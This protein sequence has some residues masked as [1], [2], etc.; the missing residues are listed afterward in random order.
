M[1]IEK[2]EI[3]AVLNKIKGAIPGKTAVPALQGVLLQNGWLTA[4][5]LN[6]GISAKLNVDTGETF[7]IPARAI[8]MIDAL[9]N[10]PVEITVDDFSIVHIKTGS[11][12]NQFASIP[13]FEFPN[14][15]E[16]DADSE[17]VTVDIDELQDAITSVLYAVS[18][19]EARPVFTGVLLEAADGYLNIVSCDGYRLAWNRLPFE[20][21]FNMI[22]PKESV[23]K[24][25]SLG[26][27]GNVEI[28]FDA[29]RAI[30]NTPEYTVFTRLL[31]GKFIDYSKQFPVHSIKVRAKRQLLMD[32]IHR[33]MICIDA[34]VKNPIR[35][36]IDGRDVTLSL[37]LPTSE[38]TESL[39][40]EDTLGKSLIIGFNAQ[41][42]HDALKSFPR[43]IVELGINTEI[44][45]V[46]IE[47]GDHRAMVLPVRLKA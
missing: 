3:S 13:V 39:N 26:I 28:S 36:E 9:P 43:D 45:P 22:L 40:F 2:A 12:K 10:G 16:V 34:K 11:I 32:C 30:F 46:T 47:D 24:L 31:D 15:P 21:V 29:K 33:A 4:Y 44:S 41:Y 6:F 17:R 20:G 23:Q 14:I 18:L 25:L 7:I 38:Y 19:N 5:N 35:I 8:A 37:A 42:L 1:K 27:R